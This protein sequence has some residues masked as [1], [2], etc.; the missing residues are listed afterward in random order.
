MTNFEISNSKVPSM[1][2][3]VPSLTDTIATSLAGRAATVG[4]TCRRIFNRVPTVRAV[5]PVTGYCPG[6][7]IELE[8]IVTQWISN[9]SAC[10][11]TIHE[12]DM[13]MT[14]FEADYRADGASLTTNEIT[15]L[16][17]DIERVF[18]SSGRLAGEEDYVDILV[19]TGLRSNLPLVQVVGIGDEDP[20]RWEDLQLYGLLTDWVRNHC[21]WLADIETLGLIMSLG[22]V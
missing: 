16:R 10:R 2:S 4:A 15:A 5:R 22:G 17:H 12:L 9:A 19:R 3:I 7:S 18:R 8:G 11:L 14:C 13:P 6:L 1:H 21:A 20:T